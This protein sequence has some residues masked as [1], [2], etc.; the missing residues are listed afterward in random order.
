ML[1]GGPLQHRPLRD[2]WFFTPAPNPDA[3]MRLLC[4]PYAGGNASFARTWPRSLP[5]DVELC[6]L[7]LPGRA[8]RAHEPIFEQVEPLVEA[9]LDVVVKLLDRPYALFG[10]SYGG[11]IGYL[12]TR[13]LAAA[14]VRAPSVLVVS[15]T[16]SPAAHGKV[17]K[18]SDLDDDEL[19]N[20]LLRLGGTAAAVLGEP[21]LRELFLPIIRS[22]LLA[23]DRHT[24]NLQA[25]PL[26]VPI[27]VFG[28]HACERVP[29]HRLTGWADVTRAGH[30]EHIFDGGHFYLHDDEPAFLREL[31]RALTQI[32]TPPN[33]RT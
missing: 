23:V 32:P 5:Q 27:V 33:D 11:L 29:P 28:A 3:R 17:P 26:D 14:G 7:R 9:M 6:A 22:D 20:A 21:E 25:P 10:H 8:P 4:F 13:R 30:R 19:C 15:S 16:P 2:Q 18:M 12:L 31:S 1:S 24:P